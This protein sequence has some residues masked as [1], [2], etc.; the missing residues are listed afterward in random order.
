MSVP[1]CNIMRIVFK[2]FIIGQFLLGG[3]F[4]SLLNAQLTT[5][6]Q[7]SNTAKTLTIFRP[8]DA[9]RIQVMKLDLEAVGND[10]LSGDYGIDSRG[11]IIM[12]LIGEVRVSGLT[13][14]ELM[15]S[16]RE[17][18]EAYMKNLY[19][20][21]RPLIR[22]TMQGAFQRP[23]AYRIDPSASLHDLVTL[24]GGPTY[25]CDLSGMVVERGGKVVKKNL[26]E[27]FEEGYS[28]EDAGIESGDQII[29]P[30][31]GRMD[32]YFYINI[33]NLLAS[34]VLLYLRLRSGYW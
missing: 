26:L 25:N 22:V 3:S 34:M 6:Y 27:S 33:I 14:V 1:K 7:W 29:A 13:E 18:L 11:Y 20:S 8:G 9:V 32:F 5:D 16:L 24:A 30:A 12:P 19:V 21:V 10:I 28:L 23:G 17:K 2:Y 4:S 15:Q 31:Q